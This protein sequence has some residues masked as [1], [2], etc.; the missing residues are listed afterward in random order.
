[1]SDIVENMSTDAVVDLSWLNTLV[2]NAGDVVDEEVDRLWVDDLFTNAANIV[3]KESYLS[4]ERRCEECSS[5]LREKCQRRPMRTGTV[6]SFVARIL[7]LEGLRN[8]LRHRFARVGAGH[9]VGSGLFWSE[10]E[11][12]FDRH[13]L[14]GAEIISCYIE[15]S[16]FLNDARDIVMEKMRENLDRYSCL[17]VNTVFNG[18]FVAKENIAVKS[19][20]TGNKQLLGMTDLRE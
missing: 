5:A 16:E 18:K 6:N 10:I 17:K 7:S 1:M 13:V 19:I 15:P 4:W 8:E 9:S 3:D 12:A 11:T 20:T 14:T 2:E